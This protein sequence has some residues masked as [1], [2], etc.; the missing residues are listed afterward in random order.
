VKINAFFSIIL[1]SGLLLSCQKGLFGAPE[2]AVLALSA[3][4]PC[5]YVQNSSGQRVSW[6]GQLPVMIAVDPQMPAEL[7]SSVKNA[8]EKWNSSTGKKLIEVQTPPAEAFRPQSTDLWNGVYW[9]TDWPEDLNYQQAITTIRFR[10]PQIL[11][12]DVVINNKFF[13]YYSSE[14]N[15]NQQVH[16]ESLMIHEFGHLLGL[17][18]LTSMPTVMWAT[19][20]GATKRDVLSEQDL[21]NLKCEY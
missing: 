16:M 18:H 21:E 8:A 5:G 17:K 15:S 6:K 2:E 9:S 10:G 20:T 13:S 19:L 4:E 3:Q 14:P 1:I 12:A 7:A 11:E